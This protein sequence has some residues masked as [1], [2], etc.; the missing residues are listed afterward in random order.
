MRTWS[1]THRAGS[2]LLRISPSS[3]RQASTTRRT[4]GWTTGGTGSAAAR[5]FWLSLIP[6]AVKSAKSEDSESEPVPLELRVEI[7]APAELAP[8]VDERPTE[9]CLLRDE[10]AYWQIVY[11]GKCVGIR[12]LK[13]LLYLHYLLLH[14]NEKVHV[15]TLAGQAS[16]CGTASPR[17]ISGLGSL[18]TAPLPFRDSGEILDPRAAR[19]YRARLVDLR[20]ELE[21]ASRWADL[22]RA[23][24]I[25]RE[26]DFLS[27]ELSSAYGLR[28]R[29]R[30]LDDPM[31]RLRKA[32]TNR[33]R[34]C[35]D[36]ISKQI[37]ALGRHLENA[38]RTGFYC[39]YSPESPI[40]WKS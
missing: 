4:G 23:D 1:N 39:S 16:D 9:L 25:R 34:S 27:A 35:I 36:R 15:S 2:P 37:P 30:K 29:A 10:G 12:Q 21:E 19:Q 7:D 6:P 5:E 11:G 31:D 22:E 13:G 8:P 18:T 33:I 3:D 17:E 28:G 14:P 24:L 38:I 26:I 20:A 40:I 32:V